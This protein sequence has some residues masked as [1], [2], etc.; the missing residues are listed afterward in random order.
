MGS[1]GPKLPSAVVVLDE[2][3]YQKS[4]HI[5]CPSNWWRFGSQLAAHFDKFTLFVPLS[6]GPCPDNARLVNTERLTIHGRF[7]YRRIEEYYRRVWTSRK[8]LLATAREL[9]G[10]N[11]LV[12]L[13]VPDPSVLLLAR[14][15]W[16]M[17]KPTML[18]V[19]GN[20]LMATS[21]A[22][23]Y[24][25]KSKV[26]RIFARRLRKMEL[27]IARRSKM[28]AAW[29][30]ELLPIFRR[31]N[32]QTILAAAPILSK[33][34]ICKRQDTCS[35]PTVRIMRVA[36]ILPNKG[37]AYLLK[38]VAELRRRGRDIKLDVA[39]GTNQPAYQEELLTLVRD[40]DIGEHVKFHGQVEFGPALFDL[41][42]HSDIHVISSISEGL[43]RCIVE[44]RAFGLPTI[45]TNVGG[46]PTVVQ[47][48]KN[49]I[50]INPRDPEE[51]VQAVELIMDDSS[52]RREIIQEGYKLA[53]LETVEFQA[54]RLAG[55]MAKALKGEPLGETANDLHLT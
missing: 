8:Q 37:L 52:L 18:F 1:I 28:V 39:G 46:I 55:L 53:R 26:A 5:L 13:R 10:K 3:F 51:I 25:L 12:I 36:E 34:H 42:S 6:E 22:D 21:Y 43:P 47:H 4:G 31:I 27:T 54:A 20:I 15:A 29:G 41:Y 45:A 9:F 2:P 17:D 11:E 14:L 44:G 24:G 7:F 35:G 32:P 30:E 40:L 38:A 19:S 48:K 33:E 16:K 49:G 23:S 50:L